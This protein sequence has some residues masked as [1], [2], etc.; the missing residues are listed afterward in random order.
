MKTFIFILLTSLFVSNS[1]IQQPAEESPEL[2]EA[3]ELSK[4][5]VKLFNEQKFDEAL[6]A[7]KR[8]L[9][10][11]ER[12]LPRTDP[13][14]TTS[15]AHIGDLYIAKQEYDNARRTFERLL[16]IQEE[17]LGP[18]DVKLAFTLDRLAVLS[19]REGRP[20]RAEEMYERAL[21]IREQA[22]GPEDVQVADSLYALGQF[23][24]SRG[25]YSRALDNY[26]RSLMIYGR[27][28]GI[29]TAE[30][31]RASTGFSCV[32]Y[33]SRNNAIFKQ[34]EQIHEQFS[35][36]SPM[37][38]S[39]SV[40]NGRA[41]RLPRPEYPAAARDRHLQGVVVV[42]VEIDEEGKVISAKDLCE[43]LPYLS[44]SAIKAAL[45]ARFSPTKLSGVPVKVRGVVQYNFV[46]R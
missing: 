8:A 22:L 27:T 23:Y 43:G 2:K 19:N 24:R 16:V 3:T 14:V 9:E 4:S 34:L 21:A 30:Y 13:R 40:L 5:V 12:L 7:A 38:P 36:A 26:R 25:E 17:Q 6:V 39:A 42:M 1:F 28:G 46:S 29:A 45:R 32:A 11:R 44:E 15:L 20:A 31:K 37:A 33:E 18:K 10:I 35:P 41:L